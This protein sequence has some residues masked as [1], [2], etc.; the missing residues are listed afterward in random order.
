MPK[1]KPILEKWE[2]LGKIGLGHR[3]GN[4]DNHLALNLIENVIRDIW[5]NVA[6]HESP[7]DIFDPPK[8]GG[9]LLSMAESLGKLY[10]R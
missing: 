8:N 6:V 7:W 5:W 2:F 4:L 10:S 9:F 3:Q 1:N